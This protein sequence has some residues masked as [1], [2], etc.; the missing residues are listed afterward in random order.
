[1]RWS[2]EKKENMNIIKGPPNHTIRHRRMFLLFRKKI[3]HETRWLEFASW[4][5]EYLWWK[6]EWSKIRECCYNVKDPRWK[7][8]RWDD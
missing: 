6:R 2:D 7:P 1:M 8:I 5:E 3:N 4:T